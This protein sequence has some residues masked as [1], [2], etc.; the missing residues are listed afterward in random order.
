MCHA[1]RHTNSDMGRDGMDVDG[2][3]DAGC[4]STSINFVVEV[5]RRQANRET[6]RT[7]CPEEAILAEFLEKTIS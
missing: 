6:R 2:T 7:S 3:F 5:A 4:R 1:D